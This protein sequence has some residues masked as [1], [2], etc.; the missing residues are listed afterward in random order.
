MDTYLHRSHQAHLD[1][2]RVNL[3]RP[4]NWLASGA[5]D[6][7]RYPKVSLAH[8]L[9]VT[10]LFWI[11]LL[12]TS[13][14]V[15]ALA[16][17]LSGFMLIAPIMA[18]GLCEISRRHEKHE[19]INF[20]LSLSGLSRNQSALLRF[21]GFLLGFSVL[22]FL[23]SGLVLMATVGDIAPPLDRTL[24]GDFFAFASP[25]QTVLYFVIG[26]LLATV[27]FMMSVVS[28]PAIIDNDI[29]ALDAA[30]T[31]VRVVLGNIL[32]MMLWAALL[33]LLTAVGISFLIA[34][35]VIFPLLGHA[36]WHA[37]RDLVTDKK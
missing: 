12:V 21:A 30:F 8:G 2:R 37:Y 6:L 13:M 11:A 26:G 15:Y 4:F 23:V 32:T 20:D 3:L 29:T 33:A 25:L 19:A 16:A 31:S 9:M 36:T 18:A 7:A 24:W 17:V 10:G 1:T 28:V 35:V 34:M 14:H 22:W 27:V 5:R